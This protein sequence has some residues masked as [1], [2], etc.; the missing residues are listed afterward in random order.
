MGQVQGFAIYSS[1]RHCRHVWHFSS[2]GLLYASSASILHAI[3]CTSLWGFIC[4]SSNRLNLRILADCCTKLLHASSSL[5]HADCCTKL[6]HASTSVLHGIRCTS[7]LHA[8]YNLLHASSSLLHAI[9]CTSLLHASSSN[10][11]RG[12]ICCAYDRFHL[13]IFA[14]WRL[15]SALPRC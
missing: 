10:D 5:L 9:R 8:S 13:C 14:D 12:D 3:R 1:K 4:C 6:L 7:L 11:R 15:W 2:A